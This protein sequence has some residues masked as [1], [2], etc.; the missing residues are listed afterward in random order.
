MMVNR[1]VD[2]LF[3]NYQNA[4]TICMSYDILR[5]NAKTVSQVLAVLAF[6]HFGILG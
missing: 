5:Q 1:P 2:W 3:T 4:E 6:Q